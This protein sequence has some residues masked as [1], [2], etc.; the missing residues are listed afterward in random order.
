MHEPSPNP[1]RDRMTALP[2]AGLTEWAAKIDGEYRADLMRYAYSLCGDVSLAEDAVQDALKL[3]YRPYCVKGSNLLLEKLGKGLIH[4]NTVTCPGFFAP[5]GRA[6]RIKPAIPDI[7]ER[8]SQIRLHEFVLTNFEMETAGY[9]TMG[10][11][12]GHEVLSLN[13]IVANRI[14]K[15]FAADPGEIVERLITHTLDLI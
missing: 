12:L 6:V 7:I 4:G 8:L 13:A 14:T 3:P 9:Y 2:V 1:P 11:L 10:R 5:Q 15:E